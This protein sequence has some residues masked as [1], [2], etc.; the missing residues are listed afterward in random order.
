MTRPHT[1]RRIDGQY[2]HKGTVI[3]IAWSCLNPACLTS[4]ASMPHL[5]TPEQRMEAE[6]IYRTGKREK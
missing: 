4:G 1:T 3:G 2:V 6:R 5:M